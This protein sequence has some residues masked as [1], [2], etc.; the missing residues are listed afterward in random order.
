M[1]KNKS[2]LRYPGGKTR[3]IETLNRYITLH[4]STTRTL[5]SPFFGGGSFELY[6][7][8]KG[9]TIKGNDLFK[10]LYTFW[11]TAQT[12][13]IELCEA[14]EGAMPIQKATFLE[15]RD[16]ITKATDPVEIAAAY[17]IINRCSFSGA[18]FCGGFSEEAS[19]G[20]LNEASLNT[21]SAVDLTN[22][23]F[24]NLDCNAFLDQNPETAD[25]VVYADPPYYISSYIYGR[26]GDMH[27][28]FDH[29]AFAAKIRQRRD[30]MVSYNDCEYIRNLYKG[31]QIEPVAW[32]YGMNNAKKASSEILILPPILTID[33]DNPPA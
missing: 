21:L 14:V 4:Y 32:T 24:S 6:L 29:A 17:Y 27:V 3:A 19:T 26:D 16:E 11:T 31:C 8:S 5:L 9:Y 1:P 20:R 7:Q 30:W 23:T 18:T 28:G 2:P 33:T 12:T 25:T 13:N 10:P 15:L 22:I